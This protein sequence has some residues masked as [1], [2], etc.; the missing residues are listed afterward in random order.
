MWHQLGR[1]SS[2]VR[3][4]R[5]TREFGEGDGANRGQES[6]T[7]GGGDRFDVAHARSDGEDANDMV[8]K[9]N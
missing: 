3:E 8:A 6:G 9:E 4:S 2:V 7:L 1:L 5:L